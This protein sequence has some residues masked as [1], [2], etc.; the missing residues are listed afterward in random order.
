MWY[1]VFNQKNFELNPKSNLNIFSMKTNE[2]DSEDE[3][4]AVGEIIFFGTKVQK[5]CNS[6]KMI[7]HL[8]ES[9]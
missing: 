3:E 2:T 7:I 8:V 4:E 5:K 6:R 1:C 9:D